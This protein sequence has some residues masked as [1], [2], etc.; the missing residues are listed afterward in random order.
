[1]EITDEWMH[2]VNKKIASLTRTVF[3]LHAE[4]VDRKDENARLK[5]KY[6]DELAAAVTA[7]QRSIDNAQKAVQNYR[8]NADA[9]C[10]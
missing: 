5:S 8:E 7:S 6:E 2:D 1:M 3:H 10:V 9:V 4:T